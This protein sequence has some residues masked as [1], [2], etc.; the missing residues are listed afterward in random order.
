MLVTLHVGKRS[1]HSK[2]Q[3]KPAPRSAALIY[4]TEQTASDI[5]TSFTNGSASDHTASCLTADTREGLGVPSDDNA[6]R[7]SGLGA[8]PALAED[9]NAEEP[10]SKR[11]AV[12]TVPVTAPSGEQAHPSMSSQASQADDARL[13]PTSLHYRLRSELQMLE[14]VEEGMR[15]LSEAE[16]TRAVA[17]AQQET[18]SLAQIL[19][20]SVCSVVSENGKLKLKGNASNTCCIWVSPSFAAGPSFVR[21][22]G[23]LLC[24]EWNVPR[25]RHGI[26]HEFEGEA[27]ESWSDT[28]S[29]SNPCCRVG[30]T[31]RH[32]ESISKG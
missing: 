14:D 29:A 4:S 32:V 17:L 3:D 9:L 16:R 13:S 21:V 7:R 12:Q 15:Q 31:Q 2:G 20:V 10:L 22:C 23:A 6:S 27:G 1:P 24:G 8:D 26:A 28:P 25:R 5:S 18:V 11:P 30:R 19:K